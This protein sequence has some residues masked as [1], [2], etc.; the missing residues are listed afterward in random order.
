LLQDH[1]YLKKQLRKQLLTKRTQ[2][3]LA[4]WQQQSQRLCDRLSNWQ[5]FR[6]AKTILAF[7]S[8]RQEPD[9]H[10]LWQRFPD[11]NW[12]FPRCMG[13]DLI[14]H[15]IAIAQFD[16]AMHSGAYD[17]LEPYP[18][19]PLLD[20]QQVDL[21]LIPA[22]ACDRLGYRLGYGG[23]YYDR[24]LPHIQGLKVGIIF[25]EFYIDQLPHDSWDIQ[26]D[27]VITD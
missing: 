1:K 22:V 21:L 4:T 24:C 9:L 14:W 5:V 19:Q 17:I 27:T 2:I 11:K 16:R 12:G 23:G 18:D 7:T 10:S 3:D 13:Q 8:F 6:Q 26:L 25:S 20:K 15:Q